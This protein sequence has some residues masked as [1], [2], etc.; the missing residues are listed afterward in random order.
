M[1]YKLAYQ[2][3]SRS[4][5]VCLLEHTWIAAWKHLCAKNTVDGTVD[6]HWSVRQGQSAV[7][8][9]KCLCGTIEA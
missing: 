8:G 6:H 3:L 1:D 2:D 9:Q 7:K 4:H 5:D